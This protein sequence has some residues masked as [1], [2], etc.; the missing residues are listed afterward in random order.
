MSAVA[1]C[2]PTYNQADY[3][4]QSVRSAFAQDFLDLEIWLSDDTSTDRTPEVVAQLQK[5]FPT[6]RAFRQEKNLGMSGNPK[7][8]V[9]QPESEFIVKL[10]SDDWLHP[11]YVSRLVALLR[12]HPR[13]GCA[14]GAVHQVNN[15]GTTTRVRRLGRA[16][17]F[18]DAEESLRA[19]IHGYRVAA[20]ICIF[21]RAA[22]AQVD[23][24]KTDLAFADDWDLAVRLADAGWGNIYCSDVLASYRVWD[25]ANNIR[26][27]RKLL[28]VAGCLR[29][30][31]E[32]LLPAYQRRG[33]SLDPITRARRRYS[34]DHSIALLSP[35]FS[36]AEREELRA[37][38]CR[39]GASPALARR[40][41][42]YRLGLG[43][44]LQWRGEMMLRAKDAVKKLIGRGAAPRSSG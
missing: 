31:E 13:A 41:F 2:V 33:W 38:L 19:L 21:R 29:V 27:R 4:A 17:G 9:R 5:E 11:A 8:V 18:Q 30:Y 39:M 10:D 40:F 6:L 28:E 42:Q 26:A 37:L 36:D 35:A 16:T 32:S 12:E 1:I 43:P 24:Y 34:L 15:A 14:H 44:F 23:Y 22:L 25:D 3:L 7:W 20:N